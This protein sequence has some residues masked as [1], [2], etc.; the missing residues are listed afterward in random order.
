MYIYIYTYTYMHTYL[1]EFIHAYTH[2]SATSRGLM[3]AS[4]SNCIALNIYTYSQKYVNISCKYTYIRTYMYEF[5]HSYTH[6][7]AARRG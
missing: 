2:T 7:L 6:I 4:C 1:H 5:M 3:I